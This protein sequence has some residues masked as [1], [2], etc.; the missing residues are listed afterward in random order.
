M[1]LPAGEAGMAGVGNGRDAVSHRT[2]EK[3]GKR[4]DN[5]AGTAGGAAESVAAGEGAKDH[6]AGD[7]TGGV[8]PPPTF[9][10]TP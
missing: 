3:G 7:R 9:V 10:S 1:R 8:R 6:R 4:K 2:L 5:Q